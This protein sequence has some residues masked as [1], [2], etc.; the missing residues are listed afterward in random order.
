[1]LRRLASRELGYEPRHDTRRT[2]ASRAWL[3]NGLVNNEGK[4]LVAG[5]RGVQRKI[6]RHRTAILLFG[7]WGPYEIKKEAFDLAVKRE[8]LL[9]GIP[10]KIPNSTFFI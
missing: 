4:W 10:T 6:S 1:V 9:D 7:I 8:R 5:G 3:T 2:Q